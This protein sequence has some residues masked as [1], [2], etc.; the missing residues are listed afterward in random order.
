MC[1]KGGNVTI[2]QVSSPDELLQLFSDTYTEGRHFR[3]HIRSC[4]HVILFTL[5]GVHV[6]E[7]LVATGHGI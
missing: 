2:T 7:S 1:C 3:Q 4:N 6:N 5:H